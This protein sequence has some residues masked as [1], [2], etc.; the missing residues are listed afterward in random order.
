LA[1]AV[2][3][4]LGLAGR[5]AARASPAGA[6]VET[7]LVTVIPGYLIYDWRRGLAR[8]AAGGPSHLRAPSSPS[9]ADPFVVLSIGLA[10]V[11]L[12][13]VLTGV[14]AA[15]R[16]RH[17]VPPGVRALAR[18][19]YARRLRRAALVTRRSGALAAAHYAAA[20]TCFVLPIGLMLAF[21]LRQAEQGASWMGLVILVAF[22]MLIAVATECSRGLF[23][24]GKRFAQIHASDARRLDPRPPV[25]LLRSFADDLTS[26]ARRLSG[27]NWSSG[28]TNDLPLTLEETVER[29]LGACGPVIAV[30]RPG[31]KL[32]PAGAARD[33]VSNEE[34]RSRVAALMTEAQRIAVIVGRTEG[35]CLEYESLTSAGAW[36]KAILLFPP[37]DPVEL[38]TRWEVLAKVA[39]W[40]SL[41]PPPKALAAAFASGG[42]PRF[43]TGTWQDDEAYEL[44]LRWLLASEPALP[45][46]TL[47]ERGVNRTGSSVGT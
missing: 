22:L 27:L 47:A 4:A 17:L 16:Y 18:G 7:L 9:S 1:F 12:V 37:V 20:V 40:D 42:E 10:A 3:I 2:G 8:L 5:S 23:A 28:S 41:V 31:E 6:I 24:R 11:A 44:G 34:W 13:W 21:F 19:V 25:L 15:F 32:P 46:G 39:G 14:V 26:I 36:P 33:Y 45:G 35:L 30:G 29:V 38:K 43:I